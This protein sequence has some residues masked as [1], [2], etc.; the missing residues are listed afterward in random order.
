MTSVG[1]AVLDSEHSRAPAL[2][3]KSRVSIG[4]LRDDVK[5]GFSPDCASSL[6]MA[7]GHGHL[8]WAAYFQNLPKNAPHLSIAR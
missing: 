3:A 4:S 7:P 1:R 5:S 6:V 2:G 8:E